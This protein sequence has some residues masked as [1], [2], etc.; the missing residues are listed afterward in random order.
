MKAVE[1]IRKIYDLP[2]KRWHKGTFRNIAVS[3]GAKLRPCG[4]DEML[5]EALKHREQIDR[6]DK[7]RVTK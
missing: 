3:G 2:G 7:L 6:M 5:S 4:F 1:E